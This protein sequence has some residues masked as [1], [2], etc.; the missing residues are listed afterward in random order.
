MYRVMFALI[1]LTSFLAGCNGTDSDSSANNLSQSN[2]V[3]AKTHPYMVDRIELAGHGDYVNSY[4]SYEVEDG[5]YIY[6]EDSK[7]YTP[8]AKVSD[9]SR[10][11]STQSVT[12]FADN[13]VDDSII[14][15]DDYKE[16]ESLYLT[17][18]SGKSKT[19]Q[20]FLQENNIIDHIGVIKLFKK[21]QKDNATTI[22]EYVDFLSALSVM[23][24]DGQNINGFLDYFMVDN[25][26]YVYGIGELAKAIQNS[27]LTSKS[28][29]EFF[30]LFKRQKIGFEELPWVLGIAKATQYCPDCSFDELVKEALGE[31]VYTQDVTL[32]SKFTGKNIA[33]ADL[34][35]I[36]KTLGAFYS[37]E[38]VRSKAVRKLGVDDVR[39]GA[40]VGLN[41]AKTI[42][43][44][45]KDSI[46][47]ESTKVINGFGVEKGTSYDDYY[48]AKLQTIPVVKICR[49]ILNVDEAPGTWNPENRGCFVTAELHAEIAYGAKLRDD[50]AEVEYIPSVSIHLTKLFVDAFR[51][52]TI[53][54]KPMA[55]DNMA[56]DRHSKKKIEL[57]YDVEFESNGVFQTFEIHVS[58]KD[59]L[60]KIT[61]PRS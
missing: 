52:V 61:P 44:I 14:G 54:A 40:K 4:K 7:T 18:E 6:L 5:K 46:P 60:F 23:D 31:D 15:I 26:Y 9:D 48:G 24:D 37:I 27:H 42:W 57:Q 34:S 20:T 45:T 2:E 22:E 39:K 30:E 51:S 10:T 29:K 49:N 3:S 56:S 25:V 35:D 59:G 33:D 50:P 53:L 36:K 28:F 12:K 8:L 13:D 32:R 41:V 17:T 47:V 55:I 1:V 11:L 38:N 19:L 43:A 16:F 58:G 21:E